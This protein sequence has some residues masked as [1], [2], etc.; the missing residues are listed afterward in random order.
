M[1]T[2]LLIKMITDSWQKQITAT[3]KIFDNLS[4]EELLHEVSPGRT[5][6][7]IYWAI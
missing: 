6:A 2:E 1:N 5:A 7:S 3:N 4:D